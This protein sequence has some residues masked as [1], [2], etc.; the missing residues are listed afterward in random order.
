MSNVQKGSE[1]L[2]FALLGI[3]P[4]QPQ[5]S[6]SNAADYPGRYALTPSFAIVITVRNGSLFAQA[7]DQSQLALRP[8]SSDRFAIT[9]VP[10]EISFE[11]NAEG[12]VAGLVLH[13]NGMDQ[14]APRG[15]A[16]PPPKEIVMPVETLREYV[17]DYPFTPQFS[18]TLTE[19]DGVLFAQATGQGKAPV[20]VSA[21]DEFYYNIVDA[22]LSFHRD[23][24]GKV[25]GLVL[26]Q[27]GR[28]M[29]APKIK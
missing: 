25:N 18:L 22:R 26:H 5:Q 8:V 12:K 19:S 24:A 29:A 27:G 17:G 21:K 1:E 23:A 6:L 2:G 7:T 10:A 13:Q 11:R 4:S 9:G 3:Q 20:F 16:L 28:D 15:E 14:R